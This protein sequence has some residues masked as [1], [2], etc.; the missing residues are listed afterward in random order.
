LGIIT[1]LCKLIPR[2]RRNFI[3]HMTKLM[4]QF[5]SIGNQQTQK[6]RLL[7]NTCSVTGLSTY[8]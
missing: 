8:T 4:L 6:S 3:S 1:G 2:Q 5:C 7:S